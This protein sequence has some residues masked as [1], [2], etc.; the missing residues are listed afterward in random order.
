MS[1]SRTRSIAIFVA[2][3]VVCLAVRLLPFRPL[4]TSLTL[5]A[6]LPMSARWGKYVAFLFGL[7]HMLLFD[8]ISAQIGPW[9]LITSLTYALLA[10]VPLKPSATQ[11]SITRYLPSAIV[12]TLVYDIITGILLGPWLFFGTSFFATCVAQVP[13]TTM[14]LI[15]NCVGSLLLS[16]YLE[17]VMRRQTKISLSFQRA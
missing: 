7:T 16:P 10:F 2:I 13:F 5:A 9:T 12:A 15:A 14:H 4:Q 6:Q 8:C 11:S 17:I 1:I 3:A